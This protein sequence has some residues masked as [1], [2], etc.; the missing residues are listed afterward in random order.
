MYRRRPFA[1]SP[2]VPT[3]TARA[4]T[5]AVRCAVREFH[6][7]VEKTGPAVNSRWPR[8]PHVTTK[9]S[10]VS[11]E[12]TRDVSLCAIFLRI[13]TTKPAKLKLRRAFCSAVD[14]CGSN[15]TFQHRWVP[16]APHGAPHGN[17]VC[18]LCCAITHPAGGQR[19]YHW[20]IGSVNEWTYDACRQTKR[21]VDH[22]RSV[23]R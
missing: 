20:P 3:T 13:S 6:A 9:P 19:R 14:R 18:G 10:Q 23:A 7:T 4:T 16:C 21:S 22:C 17:S 15:L 5:R 11:H 12:A 2:F 1:G 8:C